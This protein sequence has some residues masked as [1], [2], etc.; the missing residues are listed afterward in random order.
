MR[1]FAIFLVSLAA[2]TVAYA[3]NTFPIS[4]NV[5]VGT[6]SPGAKLDI[7]AGSTNGL[8]I[9]T[10]NESPWGFLL[11]NTSYSGGAFSIYQSNDGWIGMFANYPS[12]SSLF[13]GPNGNIGLNPNSGNV[14]IGT[15][16]PNTKLQVNGA[17]LS[18]VLNT[19]Q[20]ILGSGGVNYGLIQ[21]DTTGV[22]SLGYGANLSTLGTPVLSW[23]SG[24]NV[25]IGLTNPAAKLEVKGTATFDGAVTNTNGGY[26]Y[27]PY[28]GTIAFGLNA[29][30]VSYLG[31]G[32]ILAASGKS[33]LALGHCSTA[34]GTLVP[35]LTVVESGNV[36]IGTTNPTEKLSVKGRIRAQEV[37]VDNNNWSDYVFADDYKL[38]SLSEVEAQIKTNKHLPGVPSTQ[39]VAEKG[40]SIGDMQAVLLAKIEELTLRQIAQAKHQQAQDERIAALEAEN[41]HL[42]SQLK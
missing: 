40:V 5:G 12:G 21:N 10:A 30:G 31:I 4:G 25:G 17:I 14:G 35:D 22:W 42:K 1:T 33:A 20:L 18:S 11:K 24:G 34:M 23:N 19:P 36:G 2:T 32:S 41:T 8:Q 13:M 7:S 27:S 16:S 38:Q 37:V 3:Q 29:P 39:E 26:Y 15:T 9:T 28:N 6:T